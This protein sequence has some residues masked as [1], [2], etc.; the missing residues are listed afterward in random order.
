MEPDPAL[1]RDDLMIS[2]DPTPADP[3]VS[4]RAWGPWATIG[5]TLL[6][7][8]VMVGVQIGVLVGFA[9]A[10]GGF[11]PP[12]LQAIATGSLFLSTSTLVST[13]I[14]L[15]LLALLI[16]VRGWSIA[17]YL[18][19]R[20]PTARQA[21][22][23]AGGLI[24]LLIVTDS[25]SYALGREI[26][27]QVMVNVYRTGWVPLFLFAVVVAAPLGEEALCRGFLFRGIAASRWGPRAAIAISAVLWASLHIQYDL[28]VIAV[29]ALMGVYL[30]E[31]RRRTASVPLTM[32]LH[33]LANAIATAETM[34]QV[35]VL[36]R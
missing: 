15:G 8:A 29:I 21:L 25:A 22:I 12:N 27:P 4:P 16:R 34:I 6:A 26:V 31:V 33:A 9:A 7:L 28:Y 10:S 11:M 13:P 2:P 14:L 20:M 18:D 17:G 3:G 32:L 24:A 19:L 30:G 23:A 5:W 1:D 36:G 35:H